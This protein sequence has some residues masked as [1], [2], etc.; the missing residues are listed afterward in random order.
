MIH[1]DDYF[2][3]ERG[4]L[5]TKVPFFKG[6]TFKVLIGLIVLDTTL[7]SAIVLVMNTVGVDLVKKESSRLIEEIGNN[8]VASLDNQ[9]LQTE[10]LARSMA[11]AAEGIKDEQVLKETIR[12]MLDFDG[13]HTVAGGGIWFEPG[14]FDE[15]KVRNSFFWGRDEKDILQFYDDYNRP[16]P[17]YDEQRF[18]SDAAY[19]KA[20]LD[21]P[22]Y[23]NEEWYVVV[24]HLKG[25]GRGFWSRS[26]MDPY[27]YQPMVTVTV[28]L[29]NGAGIFKGVATVDLRLEGLH[30]LIADWS[31]K[32]GGYM[33]LLDRNNKFITFPEPTRAKTW[34]KDAR[35][36][37]AEEFITA[38]KF[39]ER[40]PKFKK[41]ADTLGFLNLKILNLAQRE[42]AFEPRLN[43]QIDRSSYQIDSREAGFINA[44]MRDPLA[45][46]TI[47]SK[48]LS[49]FELGDDGLLNEAAVVSVFHVPG[50]YWKVVIV[51]PKAEYVAVANSLKATLLKYITTI[52]LCLFVAACSYQ[53]IMIVR[54]LKVITD[55]AANIENELQRGKPINEI[56]D[57][58]IDL[59]GMGEIGRLAH[60]FNSMTDEL[61]RAH[62]SL[63]DYSRNLEVKVKERTRE[64]EAI[65]KIALENAHAA[66]MAEI[67]TGVL[68]NIGNVLN[69][70][71]VSV[72]EFRDL[73]EEKHLSSLEKAATLLEQNKHNLASFMTSDPKGRMLPHYL[74]ELSG[75]LLREHDTMIKSIAEI[76]HKINTIRDIIV[77]QHNYAKGSDF[78]EEIDLA[79]VTDDA[80]HLEAPALK[81]HRIIVIRHYSV[82][83][84]VKAPKVKLMHI[85]INLIRNAVD[86]L[87]EV[88]R[89]RTLS[90][91]I[92]KDAE[93]H[94]I[95]IVK[96]NGCGIL[97]GV[98]P[99]IFVHGFSTKGEKNGFGLHFCANT[100]VEMGG[101][102]T[103]ES[104]GRDLGATFTLTF[105]I[106]P[107]LHHESFD[108]MLA[109]T[110]IGGLT[111]VEEDR[112]RHT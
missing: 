53:L 20:F 112:R 68:H 90:I 81:E 37:D 33:F 88:H 22:G 48:Q 38:Q 78:Y 75:V 1:D 77:T 105:E 76:A 42:I 45:R 21:A 15:N 43:D 65:Q 5:D 87:T 103:V 30:E 66:G 70:L 46:E 99:K 50:S 52:I 29:H 56:E 92:T 108:K 57:R 74:K 36:N 3:A 16:G 71:K 11:N 59:E 34:F 26:Y 62:E 35:G 49:Q 83:G 23:H 47:D 54:P 98:V 101:R 80:L 95:I 79:R 104:G 72:E 18:E 17:E 32:T 44:V 10:A 82:V 6:I 63:I 25:E 61:V 28:A 69:S 58:E 19:R 39:A 107:P 8:V 106:T 96:D 51:K 64:L 94:K 4:P 85:L 91:E 41:I 110:E 84:T 9:L 13:D 102:L 60:V 86:A 100:A 31:R 97:E 7:I 14:R 2:S 40:D 89:E 27:S 67:A 109:K 55:K 111:Q 12:N 93:D 24:R 73:T